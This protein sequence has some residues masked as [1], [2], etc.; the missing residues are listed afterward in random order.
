MKYAGNLAHQQKISRKTLVCLSSARM[1][2]KSV[3]RRFLAWP[4]ASE[5]I[6]NG[7]NLLG[8][9]GELLGQHNVKSAR[10][11]SGIN[12]PVKL[13][14]ADDWIRQ[15]IVPTKK[16]SGR[17]H[18]PPIGRGQIGGG[19]EGE[20]PVVRGG[21]IPVQQAGLRALATAACRTWEASS[22]GNSSANRTRNWSPRSSSPG[23]PGSAPT[24]P[25]W[26]CSGWH[27]I[28]D[29]KAGSWWISTGG[30]P[31]AKFFPCAG[32]ALAG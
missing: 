12:Q 7:D 27:C 22:S 23:S 21:P 2:L 4:D 3:P 17:R 1:G 13:L 9:K 24:L 25:N 16:R 19:L 10:N 14:R 28:P 20:C 31:S 32:S 18:R 29:G 15:D 11:P 26:R 6:Q 30:Q 8:A 5:V